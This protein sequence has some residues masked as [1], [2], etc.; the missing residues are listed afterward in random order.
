MRVAAVPSLF[1]N[2]FEQDVLHVTVAEAAEQA[3][4]DRSLRNPSAL[5]VRSDTRRY[6][7]VVSKTEGEISV[8]M[9]F[10]A[11]EQ[12]LLPYRAVY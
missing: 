11:H 3:G 6:S 1:H 12:M 2:V 9:F 4:H 7:Q 8:N 5:T 10:A